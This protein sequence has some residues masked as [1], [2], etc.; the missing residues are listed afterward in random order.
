MVLRDRDVIIGIWR[1]LERMNLPGPISGFDTSLDASNEAF[2]GCRSIFL[3][4]LVVFE[5]AFK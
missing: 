3:E 2:K 1:R 4:P 5:D